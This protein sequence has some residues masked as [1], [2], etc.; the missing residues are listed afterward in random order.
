MA[1]KSRSDP[2]LF[3]DLWASLLLLSVVFSVVQGF[4]GNWLAAGIFGTLAVWY[5]YLTVSKNHA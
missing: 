5:G 1:R 2:F 4:E 3:G